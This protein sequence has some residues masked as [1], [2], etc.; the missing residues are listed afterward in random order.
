MPKPSLQ[1]AILF[2]ALGVS[3]FGT[4][5]AP[6]VPRHPAT[7]RDSLG[8]AG[9]SDLELWKLTRLHGPDSRAASSPDVPRSP[10]LVRLPLAY[11]QPFAPTEGPSGEGSSVEQVI[12]TTEDLEAAFQELADHETARG[13][14][15]V[16]RTVSWI[17]SRYV[18]ADR[19]ARIRTFLRD[20]YDRWGTRYVVLGGD[21]DRVPTRYVPW[22][23]EMIPA[24]LYYEC[25]DGEWN[26]D[27]DAVLGEP[28]RH[29][30]FDGT[31]NDVAV[32][33]DGKVWI[34]TY[35]G[36][37]H[38]QDG[39]FTSFREI[40][41]LPSDHVYSIGIADDGTVWAGTELGA[42]RYNGLT[43]DPFGEPEGLPSPSVLS[44]LPISRDEAW[45]GTGTGL[46]HYDEGV[47]RFPSGLPAGAISALG[48]HGEDV[49]VGTFAGVARISGSDVTVFDTTN[50]GLLSDW[51]LSVGVDDSGSV[52]FGHVGNYLSR[53]GLSR[54]DGQTWFADD[55]TAQPNFTVRDVLPIGDEIWCATS[56]G[57]FHRGSSGD[58]LLDAGDG[59]VEPN[60]FG[61]ALD[62]DSTLWLAGV[63]GL[64]HGEPGSW[65]HLDESGGLPASPQDF[66]EIDLGP[67]LVSGRIPAKD[68]Q[69]VRLYLRKL[70]DY[71]EGVGSE[72]AE[73]VLLLGEVLFT[74]FDG[75]DV[76]VDVAGR[77]PATHEVTE[78][79]ESDGRL[80]RQMALEALGNGHGIVL[81]V[82]HGSYDLLGMGRDWS[83]STTRT[84][85]ATSRTGWP[86]SSSPTTVDRV[87]STTTARWRT[88]S[89]I[90]T[91]ARW[92]RSAT[93]GPRS[94]R[95]I[96]S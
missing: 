14:P 51:V 72:A 42:A 73:R 96:R 84:S 49:W 57:L 86:A 50:S 63:D 68:A 38:L 58:V 93:R 43:W 64:I 10:R 28:A 35:H 83:S 29:L 6:A 62:A 7:L 24:D 20:A 89:S 48:R 44:I 70:A 79:Y 11:D 9:L 31:V 65:I 76:C 55:L 56:L 77:V 46:A 78:R 94:R 71:R 52:W 92:R 39:F 13:I 5:V 91:G 16:V 26:E 75:K 37:A 32:A 82:G 88:R 87:R 19:P 80:D 3:L 25:L 60:L 30:S 40:D 18:G 17:E 33:P 69:Q 61:A 90:R 12:V 27:G 47:W 95:S 1:L 81:H 15:T 23:D 36:V 53:G 21:V 74:D 34:A 41:G 22:M 4:S 8:S 66:D 59:I 54:Y 67:E 2:V 45:I 85:P